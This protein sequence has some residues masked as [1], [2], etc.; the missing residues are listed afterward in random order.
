MC[1]DRD[2]SCAS[3]AKEGECTKSP[4]YMLKECP[5]SCGLCTPKCADVH[6]DCNHW[7]KEGQCESSAR[8]DAQRSNRA[9]AHR[10]T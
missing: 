5:T 2:D 3:W 6:V 8:D 10:E 1:S 9:P 4:G 7:G